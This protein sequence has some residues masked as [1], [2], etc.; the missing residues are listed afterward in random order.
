[1]FYAF[2]HAYNKPF[3]LWG[4]KLCI[5]FLIEVLTYLY[6]DINNG[7]LSPNFHNADQQKTK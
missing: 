2:V 7:Y 6:L 3:N 1:M 4:A 5:N